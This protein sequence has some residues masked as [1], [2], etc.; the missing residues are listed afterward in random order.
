MLL[1]NEENLSQTFLQIC[2][3]TVLLGNVL[4]PGRIA[5]QEGI[6]VDTSL[7]ILGFTFATKILIHVC[8]HFKLTTFIILNASC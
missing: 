2:R 1:A 7:W 6:S 3:G 8:H 4:I 5:R